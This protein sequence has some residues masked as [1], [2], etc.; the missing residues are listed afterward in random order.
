MSLE[1]FEA[2]KLMAYRC[3]TCGFMERIWNSR[4]GVT[5]FC[6]SCRRCGKIAQHIEWHRDV[7]DPGYDPKPG[8]R[9]FRDGLPEEARAFMRARLEKSRGTPYEIPEYE[10][11]EFI[12]EATNRDTGEFRPGWPNVVIRGT[13]A[14]TLPRQE[15]R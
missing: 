5:P 4:D 14:D 10:W 1:G 3:E 15:R 8:D 9:Y 11:D 2:F 13:D 7:F 6:V 12:S